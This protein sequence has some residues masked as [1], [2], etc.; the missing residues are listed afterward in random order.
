MTARERAEAGDGRPPPPGL[1]AWLA[2]V[3]DHPDRPPPMQR[4]ALTCLVRRIDWKTGT[5]AASAAEL[6]ADAGCSERTV[7]EG[8]QLGAPRPPAGA[9]GAG[10]PPRR[11]DPVGQ[12]V[13]A[14]PARREGAGRRSQHAPGGR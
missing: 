2:A 3:R 9:D 5:G 4:H 13:A 1:P 11:R 12:R 10:P 7:M 14:V 6:A 8:D